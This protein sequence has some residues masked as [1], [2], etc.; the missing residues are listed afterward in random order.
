MTVEAEIRVMLLGAKDT[1]D[2]RDRPGDCPPSVSMREQPCQHLGLGLPAP[3]LGESDGPLFKPL[4]LWP[5]LMDDL[6]TQTTITIES[7]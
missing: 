7:L 4:H 6:G 2:G 3:E 1:E 5:F